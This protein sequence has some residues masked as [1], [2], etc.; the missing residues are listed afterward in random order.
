[1]A[2]L[3]DAPSSKGGTLAECVG[4][5]P[6]L[7]TMNKLDFAKLL[8]EKMVTKPSTFDKMLIVFS[9]EN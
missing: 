5:S 9:G 1:V 4:S 3:A 7:A 6:S 2:E 8:W